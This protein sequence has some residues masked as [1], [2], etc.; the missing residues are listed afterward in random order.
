[1]LDL[2]LYSV[3]VCRGGG[4]WKVCHVYSC[5][6]QDHRKEF[7]INGWTGT[8]A[9]YTAFHTPNHHQRTEQRVFHTVVTLSS[10]NG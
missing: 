6:D 2:P 4:L 1:M 9:G 5:L 10:A 7:N 3:C 8:T